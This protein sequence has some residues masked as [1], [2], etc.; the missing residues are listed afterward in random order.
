MSSNSAYPWFFFYRIARIT[1][2]VFLPTLFLILFLYRSSYKKGLV[3]QTITQMESELKII[4]AT[5]IAGRISPKV[6]CET[7]PP[8]SSEVSVLDSG[9]KVL[10]DTQ[11]KNLLG[12]T[13]HDL[14]RDGLHSE[15]KKSEFFRGQ[16]IFSYASLPEGILRKVI[17]LS[18]L[19]ENLDEFDR[20]LFLR[21]VPFALLSYLVFIFLFYRSTKPLGIILSKVEK[22]KDDIP[23]NK[24]LELLY[25]RNEWAA[26]EEALNKA[27]QKLQTQVKEVRSEN[28]K[29][30][31]ILESINDEI[32]AVDRFET[33]LFYNTKFLNN[34]IWRREGQEINPKIWHIFE[35]EVLEAFRSVLRTGT[36]VSLKALKF[37]QSHSPEKFFDLTITPLRSANVQT[38][39]LGV[40]YDVTEVKRNELMRVDFVANISHEIRTPLTS[41]RG[42]SQVLENQTDK[43]DPSLRPFLQKII[44]NTERM[45]SLFNDLLNLSVI[46][47]KNE[48]RVEDFSLVETIE[49]ASGAI[50]ANYPNKNVTVKKHVELETY[51]GDPRLFEQVLINLLD[52]ACKYAGEEIEISIDA[53]VA[54]SELLLS[55][56]DNGPGISKEHLARIFER[57]YRV[58][59][60]RE[61]S[62]G[63]GLGL[64]IVKQIILKHGGKIFA[65]SEGPGT[66]TTFIMQLP[67]RRDT[68][69]REHKSI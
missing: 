8:A 5:L 24:N 47:S 48:L 6:W 12:E 23:F 55:V 41:V 13:L 7:L 44:T 15:L 45:L 54:D 46:E 10:C 68:L 69:A 66:G 37:P 32:I 9:G 49:N 50:A 52:N 26:I 11:D 31:A 51:R 56:S 4:R 2:I 57:F 53:R 17:P 18:S 3:A 38:G 16:A 43:V 67:L 29:T 42:F 22:F 35:G 36:S 25:K 27:D 21:I 40:L 60:S 39:A 28:E 14:P 58:D 33:I 1:L 62:R 64:S 61:S 20:V 59:Y 63:T 65:K 34:F 19:R 30:N